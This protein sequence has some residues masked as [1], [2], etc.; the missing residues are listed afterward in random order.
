MV[1]S[2][3]AHEVKALASDKP[4]S[5][6]GGRE[7]TPASCLLTATLVLKHARVHAHRIIK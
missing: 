2:K 4:K 3:M 5:H 1:G 7:L 6:G